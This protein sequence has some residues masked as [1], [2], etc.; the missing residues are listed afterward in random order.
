MHT[1]T[2]LDQQHDEDISSTLCIKLSKQK[3]QYYF[4]SV[5]TMI[6]SVMKK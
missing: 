6:I 5:I 3:P 1:H 2:V 4:T